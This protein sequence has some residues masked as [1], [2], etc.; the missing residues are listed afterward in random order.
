MPARHQH[1]PKSSPAPADGR[2]THHSVAQAARQHDGSGALVA[3]RPKATTGAD[4]S[5]R[6]YQPGRVGPNSSSLGTR[7][8]V[9]FPAHCRPARCAACGTGR[10]PVRPSCRTFEDEEAGHRVLIVRV[11]GTGDEVFVHVSNVEAGAARPWP[12]VRPSSSRSAQAQARGSQERPPRVSR[13][14]SRNRR[15]C[16]G[17]PVSS[18][19]HGSRAAQPVR[20][21]EPG[22]PFGQVVAW[23]SPTGGSGRASRVTDLAQAATP[24]QLHRTTAP[25]VAM[26][27][28]HKDPN[29][30][31]RE[32]RG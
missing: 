19:A 31:L 12:R 10:T 15:G 23:S 32:R 5:R 27:K 11:R 20:A 29:D 26:R 24:T 22:P 30:H 9:L 4:V 16:L 6:D 2:G 28:E 13:L 25:N 18:R 1:D 3:R 7:R 14:T 8:A 17:D 21:S